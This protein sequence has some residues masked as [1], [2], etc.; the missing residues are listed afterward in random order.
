[1]R[2]ARARDRA[3]SDLQARALSAKRVR[4][5]C[6][7]R[8]ALRVEQLKL[9]LDLPEPLRVARLLAL[10]VVE[11]RGQLGLLRPHDLKRLLRLGDH[12][13]EL[14][15]RAA[16]PRS[17]AGDRPPSAQRCGGAHCLQYSLPPILAA[18]P[19]ARLPCRTVAGRM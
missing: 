10:C 19:R 13:L 16:P 8:A 18:S 5:W 9:S 2:A 3:C 1:M 14:P 7:L 6:G 17:A 15:A 11:R 4:L 12:L